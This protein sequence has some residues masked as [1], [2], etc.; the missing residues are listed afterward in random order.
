MTWKQKNSEEV[1]IRC[2]STNGGCVSLVS[3]N[4]RTGLFFVFPVSYIREWVMTGYNKNTDKMVLFKK[5][6][7][8]QK[9]INQCFKE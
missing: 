8:F 4:V 9:Y 3:G 2:S 7:S 5:D 6:I 1:G